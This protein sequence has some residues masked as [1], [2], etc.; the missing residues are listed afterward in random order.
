[1][2]HAN[3]LIRS[4]NEITQYDQHI[5]PSVFWSGLHLVWSGLIIQGRP[6]QINQSIRLLHLSTNEA[7]KQPDQIN[8]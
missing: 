7:C 1:M 6:D 3:N 4:I 8:Q 5:N 2:K